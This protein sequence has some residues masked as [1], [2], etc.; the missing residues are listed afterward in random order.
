MEV[1]EE[2]RNANS[3]NQFR[4]PSVPYVSAVHVNKQW[5][6]RSSYS[7]LWS[8]GQV[9]RSACLRT[10]SWVTCGTRTLWGPSVR[11]NICGGD[12]WACRPSAEV[13]TPRG[14]FNDAALTECTETAAYLQN[15]TQKAHPASSKT[16]CYLLVIALYLYFDSDRDHGS[17]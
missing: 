5:A 6:S 1:C 4:R 7:R 14:T 9:R 3:L 16:W 12:I 13:I 11:V 8:R 2:H 17:R 15:L 10:D